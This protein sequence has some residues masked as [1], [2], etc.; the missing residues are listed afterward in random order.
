MALAPTS[1][2]SGPDPNE[3]FG[4]K[5]FRAYI[6]GS[7]LLV[8][9]FNFIDRAILAILNDPIKESLNLEDWH[10]GLLGG[11]AFALLYVTLGIPIARVAE[12]VS[13]KW[14]IIT[15]LVL[16]S[17]MTVLCGMATSFIMLFILRIGVGIGEAGC[18]P[19][20]QSLI[21]D[22][23]KPSSRAT[24][25]SIYALGV[26]LGAM[27]AGLAGGPIN[28]YVTGS[29]VYGVLQSWGLTSIAN[30]IDWQSLEGWRIAFFAVGLP[31]IIFAIILAVTMKDPPRGYTDPPQAVKPKAANFGEVLSIL[32]SKPTFIHVVIG[33]GIASFAGYGIGHFVPAYFI[34]IHELTLT[35][36]AVYY[37]LILGLCGATG[38]FLSGYLADKLARRIPKALSWLPAIGMTA[39]VPLYVF[40]FMQDTL[41]LTMPPLM[42]AALLHYFYLGPMYAVVGGVVDSRMRATSVAIAL[43]FVN[44]IGLAF[45]PTAA[46]ATSSFIKGRILSIGND[47]LSIKVCKGASNLSEAA[48]QACAQADASGLQLAIVIFACLYVWASVHYLVAGKTL[49]RD[50]IALPS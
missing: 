16:W 43:F 20:A 2:V 39:S 28:D 37:S 24:A 9:I 22:Y 27:I 4:S 38:V 34:R 15:S 30:M 1:T 40:G 49:R 29:N 7:L 10:M 19:P 45:G 31:G 33:A 26:P 8:Y 5:G 13:R 35:Q 50:M 3:G 47:D 17:V 18:T 41:W 36:A 6:L 44:L 12:R 23:F 32:K 48:A 25:V 46:G 14:I 21:A 11:L 42:L